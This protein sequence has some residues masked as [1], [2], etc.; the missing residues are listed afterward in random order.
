MM[1]GSQKNVFL[2]GEGSR[3]F[4]YWIFKY[5]GVGYY[6]LS[7]NCT[8]KMFTIILAETEEWI[9]FSFFIRFVEINAGIYG[10]G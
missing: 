10:N 2:E 3:A 7:V 6:S 5:H 4:Q 1:V 8:V 9:F